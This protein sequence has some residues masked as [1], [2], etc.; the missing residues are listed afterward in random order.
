MSNSVLAAQVRARTWMDSLKNR[1]SESEVGQG[2]VEY[3]GLIVIVALV[4][5]LI[6]AAIDGAGLGD[7]LTTQIDKILNPGH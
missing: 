6:Y 3:A 4:I 7:H 1:L 5:G 2:A